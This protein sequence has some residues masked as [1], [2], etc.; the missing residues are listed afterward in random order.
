[1]AIRA[2]VPGEIV[3]LEADLAGGAARGSRDSRHD[4]SSDQQRP[5]DP[6]DSQIRREGRES[7]APTFETTTITIGTR[8]NAIVKAARR[9]LLL[10]I[11]RWNLK[12]PFRM[13]G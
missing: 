4:Q 13:S 2:S 12:M 1:M 7:Y 3:L 10:R 9:G 6:H 5:K 8:N 11:C